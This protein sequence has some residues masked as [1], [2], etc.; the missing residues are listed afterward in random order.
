V[1]GKDRP[2]ARPADGAG[3]PEDGH[4]PPSSKASTSSAGKGKSKTA[5]AWERPLEYRETRRSLFGA[6]RILGEVLR[7]SEVV[8]EEE[9]DAIAKD[10]LDIVERFPFLEPYLRVTIRI[11]GPLAALEQLWT[12]LSRVLR[13]SRIKR[14]SFGRRRQAPAP[15]EPALSE[16]DFQPAVEPAAAAES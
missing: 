8:T 13:S 4:S 1:K 15:A 14:P 9:F 11:L 2:V 3:A 16:H 10:W 5:E 6:V 12:K 7:S